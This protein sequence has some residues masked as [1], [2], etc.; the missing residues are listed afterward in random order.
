MKKND[1]IYLNSNR[2]YSLI[3]FIFLFLALPVQADLLG[4]GQSFFIDSGYDFKGRSS[5]NA[6]LRQIGDHAYIYVENNYWNSVNS[7]AQNEMLT[8]IGTLLNEFDTKIYQIETDYFGPEPN[9]GIDKDP[10]IV[11]LI[12]PL[13]ENA[14]GYFSTGNQYSRQQ[15]ADSNE[16]EL[17]YLNS[18]VLSDNRKAVTFLAHEFQHLISF[19]QKEFL[20]D[21]SEDTW[22]NETRSELAVGLIGHDDIFIG[23]NLQ[24]RLQSFINNPSDSLTEWKNLAADYGQIAMFG[25]YLDENWPGVISDSLKNN[26]VG[27]N[28]LNLSL[29]KN[30]VDDFFTVFLH[31]MIANIVNDVSTNPKFGYIETGLQ[32]FQVAP[33]KTFTNLLDTST[34]AYSELIKDW[35]A[36]WYEISQFP[37]GQNKILKIEFSSS[38]LTSFS[39]PSLIFKP[40]G[41]K[42]VRNFEPKFGAA[43]FYLEGI[44]TDLNKII[45]MPVKR[46]KISGFGDNEDPINLSFT[47]D[48]I[49]SAPVELLSTPAPMKPLSYVNVTAKPSDF[50]LKEGDFIRAEGDN[51]VY[52]INDFGYKRLIISPKICLQYG[53]LS[54]RGCFGAVKIVVPSTRDAF[55]TSHFLTNGELNNGKLYSFEITGDDSAQLHHLEMTGDNFMKTGGDFKS[56]F[57]INTLEQNSYK[58]SLPYFNLP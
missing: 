16:R 27:I 42:E 35:Q 49:K 28:G 37:N 7:Q 14:G 33:T 18:S 36:N 38:S 10:K 9:P 12:T 31:W 26:A 43:T 34:F 5:V 41:T 58:L 44:G 8:N 55:K 30:G 50:N 20:H 6:T 24:R 25:K 2:W 56:V 4:Q 22:L 39:V 3:I 53:H 19:N 57:L 1:N 54:Q 32:D 23:S 48:R 40:D 52:I 46:D 15:S 21:I 13:I 17:I 47:I 11:I 45:L 29:L 51:D